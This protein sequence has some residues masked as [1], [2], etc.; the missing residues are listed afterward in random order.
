MYCC[1]CPTFRYESGVVLCVRALHDLGRDAEFE[2]FGYHGRG[3]DTPC[4]SLNPSQQAAFSG[5]YL[6]HVSSAI[7]RVAIELLKK[8]TWS[9]LLSSTLT[10]LHSGCIAALT[11][12]VHDIC[13][14]KDKGCINCYSLVLVSLP[15][16][17]EL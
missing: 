6:C 16:F 11:L 17:Y 13:L 2:A 15:E 8:S 5:C 3:E 10:V 14:Q 1:I 7:A 4:Q 9:T 12:L